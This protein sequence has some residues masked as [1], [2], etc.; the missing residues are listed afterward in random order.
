MWILVSYLSQQVVN[1]VP[2][3]L[4]SLLIAT[5]HKVTSGSGAT[6][7]HSVIVS[8]QN[9]LFSTMPIFSTRHP[10]LKRFP[11]VSSYFLTSIST[12]NTIWT[13]IFA[14]FF[15]W[16]GSL[17]TY[18]A[19]LWSWPPVIYELLATKH[20][21]QLIFLCVFPHLLTISKYDNPRKLYWY[22]CSLI[23]LCR[24]TDSSSSLY[25]WN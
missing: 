8:T 23:P 10:I 9:K 7:Q 13:R 12:P 3:S 19:G 1:V 21:T 4:N 16:L 24:V 22:I 20:L 25:D 14:V 17:H 5:S 18:C 15:I 2:E 6:V 11:M